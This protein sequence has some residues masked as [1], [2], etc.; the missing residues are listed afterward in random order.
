MGVMSFA[1]IKKCIHLADAFLSKLIK[2][3]ADH[4]CYQDSVKRILS[5]CLMKHFTFG[6]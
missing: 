3:A 5:A 6:Q 2:H 4:Q 1:F